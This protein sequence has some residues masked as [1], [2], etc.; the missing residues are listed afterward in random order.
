MSRSAKRTP[1]PADID[2]A[3]A[4]A[5]AQATAAHF[6]EELAAAGITFAEWREFMAAEPPPFDW[7]I[8]GVVAKGMKGDLL[9]KSKRWK[10]F[11]A[12]QLALCVSAGIPFLYEASRRL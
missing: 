10:S 3:I 11:F 9:A 6:A 8:D 2:D 7:I 1:A 5:Q 12:M 4:E